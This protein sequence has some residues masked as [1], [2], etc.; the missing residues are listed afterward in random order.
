MAVP[1]KPFYVLRNINIKQKCPRIGNTDRHCYVKI[2]SNFKK[3]YISIFKS[4]TFYLHHF[5]FITHVKMAIL[6][7]SEQKTILKSENQIKPQDSIK[8]S[9]PARLESLKSLISVGKGVWWISSIWPWMLSSPK[10]S[11]T[12][13]H[14]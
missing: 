4:Y 8:L 6:T 10:N 12:P 2:I 1:Y 5:F 7:I 11:F 13:I 14:S 3:I 9:W